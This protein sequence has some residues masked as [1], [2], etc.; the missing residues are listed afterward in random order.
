ARPY[1]PAHRRIG[2]ARPRIQTAGEVL[3][4]LEPMLLAQVLG[5]CRA[6]HALVAIDDDLVVGVQL[7]G[8]QLD[9]LDRD[10]H[11][12]LEPA[13]LGLPVLAH[14]EQQRAIVAL[15]TGLQLV[16]GNLTH[17]LSW[18][19]ATWP[20]TPAHA[21]TRPGGAWRASDGGPQL[22]DIQ[23]SELPSARRRAADQEV[24]EPAVHDLPVLED[25][26]VAARVEPA[27]AA[28]REALGGL[29]TVRGGDGRIL[30]TV[31]QEDGHVER[32][33]GAP[34]VGAALD[35]VVGERAYRAQPRPACG[36]RGAGR[37]LP[38][39][40]KGHLVGGRRVKTSR[41]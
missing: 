15:E 26:K 8:P 41:D 19:A 31:D 28:A 36:G 3:H 17:G 11:G 1:V 12:V 35:E 5:D 30:T 38:A 7:L 13:E 9:L 27:H 24:G 6:A 4:V 20:P 16:R 37:V 22:G 39:D 34:I 18:G 32:G 21:R 10:V 14:I 29:R 23:K 40:E 33:D 25:R 2:G